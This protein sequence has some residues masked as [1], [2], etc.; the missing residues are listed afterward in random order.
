MLVTECHAVPLPLL[1]CNA[2]QRGDDNRGKKTVV[3]EK[4][5]FL[6]VGAGSHW[7]TSRLLFHLIATFCERFPPNFQCKVSDTF[8]G[9][10]QRF[11]PLVLFKYIKIQKS[12][13]LKSR[14]REVG[15]SWLQRW[16]CS[17]AA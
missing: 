16:R 6:T 4:I 7:K 9:P 13:W 10:I 1:G 5:N 14:N 12:F 8:V 17:N 3:S 15:S 11:L 2:S